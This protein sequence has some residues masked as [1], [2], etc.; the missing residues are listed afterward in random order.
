MLLV[1]RAVAP[2]W[3][4]KRSASSGVRQK[5]VAKTA[6]VKHCSLHLVAPD[7]GQLTIKM[8]GHPPFGAQIILH[9]PAY[10]AAQ[11][12]RAGV[13][14]G[15]DG[16]CCTHLCQP[17]NLAA[18]ADTWTE[19]P[20]IGQL[21]PVGD[22][23]ISSCCLCFGLHTEEQE[24]TNFRSQYSVY[25]IEDSRN[26]LFRSGQH[27]DQIFQGLI[28]RTRSRRDIPH[29]R[30]SFGRKTRPQHRRAEPAP[31][32]AGGRERPTYK[33][34]V[35]KVHFGKVTLT[36]DT[37]GEHGWR[38][39]A[40]GHNAAALWRGR[41]LPRFPALVARLRG[42]RDRGL[43]TIEYLDQAF[44]ADQRRDQLPASAP[45]GRLR[46][47][48]SDLNKPRMRAV[49]AA[50]LTCGQIPMGFRLRDLVTQVRL[51]GGTLAATSGTR[52]AA[53]DLRKRRAK[54]FVLRRTRS[55]RY[56]VPPQG[57]R[58][59]AALVVWRE[60]VIK[61]LRAGIRTPPQGLAPAS[62][63]SLAAH[64]HPLRSDR[65][66]LLADLGLAA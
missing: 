18:V 60:Q 34:T 63:T 57:R 58:T 9:G 51:R 65:H 37:K 12:T 59:S 46:G 53:S 31:R 55:Q 19:E 42:M 39:A 23:W 13:P 66:L 33:L 27:L 25:H 36:A 15:T 64:Y 62:H 4:V 1:C 10:V 14:F 2:G 44:V 49:L 20:V 17:H 5:L 6:F 26:L 11:A 38:F 41:V 43:D 30:T 16:Q 54:G 8:S 21:L 61:P 40:L 50:T 3:E 28:D 22:R 47:G 48:G 35:C 7:G 29:L 32:E 56:E 45:L 52:P 24:R